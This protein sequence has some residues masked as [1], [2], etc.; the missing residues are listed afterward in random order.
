MLGNLT[1]GDAG[2]PC[3]EWVEGYPEWVGV[4]FAIYF[5]LAPRH[6]CNKLCYL[7]PPIGAPLPILALLERETLRNHPLKNEREEMV[8]LLGS[9]H[10]IGY[11]FSQILHCRWA[12]IQASFRLKSLIN[13]RT[14]ESTTGFYATIGQEGQLLVLVIASQCHVQTRT[15]EDMVSVCV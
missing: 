11:T 10:V 7:D 5:L 1:G 15:V 4:A 14:R 13:A 9:L 3:P 8:H 12:H 6:H 2:Q